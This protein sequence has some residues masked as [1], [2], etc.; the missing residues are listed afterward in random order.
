[1]KNIF[2]KQVILLLTLMLGGFQLAHA[3]ESHSAALTKRS[4]MKAD[5]DNVVS[6]KG[7]WAKLAGRF[8]KRPEFAYVENAPDLPNVLIYGD[9][10]SI[11]YTQ[12]V[13]KNIG[14]QANVYRLYKNGGNSTVLIPA[15]TQMH[16]VMRDVTLDQPWTFQWDVIHF[17]VGLHDLTVI[18][19][20]DNGSEPESRTSIEDY[21]KNLRSILA[22]LQE[23]APDAKLIFATT[24]PVPEGA[25][26][27]TRIAGDSKK[28][29]E[30]ALEVLAD[31]PEVIINDLFTLTKP[32]QPKWWSEPGNVHYNKTG[33][34]AQGDQVA[35]TILKA[36]EQSDAE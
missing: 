20:T 18:E 1:M 28:Y 5:T 23:L 25:F 21:K 32:N 15:M 14:V 4:A 24:T 34:N 36:L 9:S 3:Q 35:E 31:Y 26:N 10:I 16:D 29:N 27:P 8:A 13:R 19:P 7:Q 6:A 11:G 22:Y 33:S 12:R 30:A 17:N 2:D